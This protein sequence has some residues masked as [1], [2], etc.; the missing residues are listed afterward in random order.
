[1]IP[2]DIAIILQEKKM[3]PEAALT[4]RQGKRLGKRL[5][6]DNLRFFIGFY[7]S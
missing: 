7:R 2:D 4:C 6:Q 5:M 3:I 1:M